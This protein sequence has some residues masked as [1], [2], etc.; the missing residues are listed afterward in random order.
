MHSAHSFKDIVKINLICFK[1]SLI[2]NSDN[3]WYKT[4]TSQ[5]LA[6]GKVQNHE[7]CNKTERFETTTQQS[8]PLVQTAAISFTGYTVTTSAEITPKLRKSMLGA[9]GQNKE[10]VTAQ[11]I[12]R[13][14]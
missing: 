3:S 14:G 5:H 1:N 10:T 2:F 9:W 11:Y 12:K 7:F 6:T 13:P 4:H 8:P